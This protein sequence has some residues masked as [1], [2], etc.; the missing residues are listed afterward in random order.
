LRDYSQKNW[1]FVAFP[2]RNIELL[3]PGENFSL[4][5]ALVT[6]VLGL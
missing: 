3:F 2:P 6:A 4:M 1:E 5:L